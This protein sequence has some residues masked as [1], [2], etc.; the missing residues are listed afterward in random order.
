MTQSE[1]SVRGITARDSTFF[2]NTC[3]SASQMSQ[4]FGVIVADVEVLPEDLANQIAFSKDY[5]QRIKSLGLPVGRFLAPAAA[6]WFSGKF[7]L[8]TVSSFRRARTIVLHQI[9]VLS[10]LS[11]SIFARLPLALD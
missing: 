6:E 4:P 2:E 10:P 8:G 5:R 9:L 3:Q 11:N 7:I 1:V